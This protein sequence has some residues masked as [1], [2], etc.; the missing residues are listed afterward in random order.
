M[1][2][3]PY[4]HEE[5]YK[6][7]H[8]LISKTGIP[9]ISKE[10]SDLVIQYL[11]DMEHGLNVSIASVKGGRSYIRLN[12]L[13]EKMRFFSM[14][15]ESLYNCKL[16]DITEPQLLLFF[17]KMRKGEIARKDGKRYTSTSYFVKVSFT[18]FLQ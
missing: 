16:I 4:N 7:W 8:A 11:D 10:N 13:R 17:S 9:D 5:R 12:T 6:K 2:I 15:F 3:D 1:K 18:Y 14:K